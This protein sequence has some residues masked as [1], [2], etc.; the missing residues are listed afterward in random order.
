M[1]ARLDTFFSDVSILVAHPPPHNT[2]DKV[3][4]RFPS[5]SKAL[6]QLTLKYQPS[7]LICG[8]IHENAGAAFLGRTLVV[9][10]SMAKKGAGMLIDYQEGK[11]PQATML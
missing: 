3:M 10:C 5:G 4:G 6:R 11:E 2:V 8:H 9:N 1:I 7:V